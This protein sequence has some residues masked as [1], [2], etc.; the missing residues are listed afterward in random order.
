MFEFRS[1]RGWAGS[2]EPEMKWWLGTARSRRPAGLNQR[3]TPRFA[4]QQLSCPLGELLDVSLTGMRVACKGKPPVVRGGVLRFTIGSGSQRMALAGQVV[5][6][7]RKGLRAFELGVMFVGITEVQKRAL[8]SLVKFGFVRTKQEMNGA[9]AGRGTS[10]GG[11][12]SGVRVSASVSD[13]YRTLGVARDATLEQVRRAFHELAMKWHPDHT[14]AGNEAA[15]DA[16]G[17]G[18]GTSG[19][20]DAAKM[21]QRVHEAY[22]VLKDPTKRK[23]YDEMLDR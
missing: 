2:M 21:F 18:G 15:R 22:A 11:A 4:A 3:L 12:S 16:S 6:V 20:G 1:S 9:A 17:G 14:G 13:H 23:S 19:G 7:R 5:R 8:D 10:G